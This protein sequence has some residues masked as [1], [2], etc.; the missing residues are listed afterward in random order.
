MDWFG[1]N[2]IIGKG[3]SWLGDNKDGIETGLNQVVLNTA[4]SGNMARVSNVSIR[5]KYEGRTRRT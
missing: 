5:D 1:E 3:V 4:L 2:G